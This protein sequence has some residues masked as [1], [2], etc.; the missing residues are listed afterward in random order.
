MAG[1]FNKANHLI[2]Q[3]SSEH[4]DVQVI[5]SSSAKA[6]DVLDTF[7]ANEAY[8]YHERAHLD[9]MKI[10]VGDIFMMPSPGNGPDGSAS[11][12]RPAS[13]RRQQVEPSTVPLSNA[14]S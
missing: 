14:I 7:D 3:L 4:E 9:T 5:T 2:N 8:K 6:N 12:D 10:N 1:S 13:P 11:N